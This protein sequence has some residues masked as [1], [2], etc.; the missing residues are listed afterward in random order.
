M[1]ST[2]VQ[3]LSSML[4]DH[5]KLK[6]VHDEILKLTEWRD[7]VLDEVCAPVIDWVSHCEL[8]ACR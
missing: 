8:F 7:A 1:A 4:A 6:I 2:Q 5:T 3:R